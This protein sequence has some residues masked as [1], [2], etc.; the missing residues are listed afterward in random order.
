M[1][2]GFNRVVH[3]V[4]AVRFHDGHVHGLLDVFVGA[5]DEASFLRDVG[6]YLVGAFGGPEGF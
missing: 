4:A 2:G 3:A 1:A 5:E 6:D